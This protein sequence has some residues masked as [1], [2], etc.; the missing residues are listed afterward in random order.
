VSTTTIPVG[1]FS[2]SVSFTWDYC[3]SS[4]CFGT[5]SGSGNQL[6]GSGD[7]SG[8]I[9]FNPN[10]GGFSGSIGVANPSYTAQSFVGDGIKIVGDGNYVGDI[11]YQINGGSVSFGD[12]INGD[13]PSLYEYMWT[14]SSSNGDWGCPT[15]PVGLLE[16]EEPPGEPVLCNIEEIS[17][18]P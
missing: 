9:T 7:L 11:T 15:S 10:N 3:D 8:T 16:D 13:N 2:G 12:Y 18:T 6:I 5:I 14:G 4:Q 1:T 17:Y